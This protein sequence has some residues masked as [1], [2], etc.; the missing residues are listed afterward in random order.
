MPSLLISG[1]QT[2]L[3]I[4]LIWVFFCTQEHTE[5]IL[6]EFHKDVGMSKTEVTFAVGSY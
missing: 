6:K 1:M 3:W 2:C 4:L 5:D